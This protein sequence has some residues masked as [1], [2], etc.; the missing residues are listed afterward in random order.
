MIDPMKYIYHLVLET[1]Q[2]KKYELTNFIT[3][4]G[5]E[6]LEKELAAR[7][8]FSAKNDK[9]S[10]GRLSSLAKPGCYVYLYYQYNNG[11]LKEAVRGRIV[12]W[13]PSASGSSEL[14]KVKAYDNLYDLQESEDNLYFSSGSGTKQIISTIFSRWGIRIA[15]YTG[16]NV[17]HGSIKEAKKKLGQMVVET[18][19]EAKKKGGGDAVVRSVQGNVQILSTGSNTSVYH[20]EET[21]NL[22]SASHKISTAG[23]VTRVKVIGEEDSDGR[24]PLEATV[25]GQT[26]Y[27]IRQKIVTRGSDESIGEAKKAAG[28]IIK[29]DGKPKEEIKVTTVEIPLIRKGD[30]VHV[31]MSTGTGYFQVLSIVHDCDKMEMQMNLRKTKVASGNNSDSLKEKKG[32]YEVGDVVNFHGGKHYVSSYASNAASVGLAPGPAK[33]EYTNPGSPHPWCIVTEDWSVTHVWGWVDEG[34]F[35]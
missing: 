1:E 23:M 20:F 10:K 24:R 7:I 11:A 33:I 13:N 32:S 9:T 27:G 29:E 34:S 3:D 12:E 19:S 35:D 21:K 2:G 17:T 30:L 14:L 16:P 25:D 28:E 31:K 4:L 26:K 22:T 5:W 8:S 15:K 18:L 6:E